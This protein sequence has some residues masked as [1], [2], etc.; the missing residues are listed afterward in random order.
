MTNKPALMRSSKYALSHCVRIHT[1]QDDAAYRCISWGPD[2]EG[3]NGV[4]LGKDVPL[5]VRRGTGHRAAVLCCAVACRALWCWHVGPPVLR[6]AV[7]C[8][9]SPRA[10]VGTDTD[11]LRL[12][13][14]PSH[15]PQ[16]GIMLEAVIKAITPKI[17]SW[18]QYA[19]AAYF[20]YQ[21]KVMKNPAY[22]RYVPD[23]TKCVEHFALHAGGYAVLKGIQQG[24]NL[25]VEAVLPSFASLRDMGNTSS[26][27]TWYT[28]GYLESQDMVKKGH[29]IMQVGAGGGMKGG[30][31]IWTALQDNHYVHPCW[32]H[33]AG[34]P[35]T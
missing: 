3:V 5:Q 24:M 17:M 18:G 2:P 30:V 15:A 35:Y 22:K 16:A 23:Y 11:A 31:N 1:G 4:F 34:R 14:R 32:M 9:L 25:P 29:R 19:E 13:P 10:C 33:V 27:T 6:H 12:P 7:D 8:C 26:S 28:M 20:M 21:K